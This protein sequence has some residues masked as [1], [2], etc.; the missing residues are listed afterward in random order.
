MPT[1]LLDTNNIHNYVEDDG[2]AVKLQKAIIGTAGQ[3][4]VIGNDGQVT[5]V[6]L[7]NVSEVG[8]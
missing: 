4:V 8:A 5:T 2:K 6:S 7:T 1:I 3:F